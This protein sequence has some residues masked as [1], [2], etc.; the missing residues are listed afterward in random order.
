MK[1]HARL[2]V[3]ESVFFFSLASIIA[4]SLIGWRQVALILSVIVAA[5]GRIAL[6]Y[7][8]ECL[9]GCNSLSAKISMVPIIALVALSVFLI[10]FRRHPFLMVALFILF[11][12][13]VIW[14]VA[15]LLHWIDRGRSRSSLNEDT[16]SKSSRS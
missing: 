12:L 4:L 9:A 5:A 7:Y 10:S 2:A 16:D 8:Y 3:L 15:M 11:L 6:D 14:K 13:L 1:P